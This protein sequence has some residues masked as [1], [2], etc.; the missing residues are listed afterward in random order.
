MRDTG[1]RNCEQD[2][3]QCRMST[4]SMHRTPHA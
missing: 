3:R 4:E 2:Q 1:D